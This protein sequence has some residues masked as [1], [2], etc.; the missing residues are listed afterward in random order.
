[1]NVKISSQH[2]FLAGFWFDS[3]LNF[4]HYTVEVD[5][6]TATP[7]I[8]EQNVAFLRIRYILEDALSDVVFINHDETDAIDAMINSGM[9]VAITPEEP[10]DQIIGMLIHSKLSTV[11]QNRV[12]IRSVRVSSVRGDNIIYEHDDAE[13]NPLMATD[14][15]WSSLDPDDIRTIGIDDQISVIAANRHW[16]DL[17]LGWIDTEETESTENIVVF[18][19]FRRDED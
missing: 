19:E 2:K 6:L 5:M 17:E 13:F 1:M 4:N 16:R 10:V 11:T 12:I 8:L 3:Q 7:D 15:W 18:G 9:S 14:G